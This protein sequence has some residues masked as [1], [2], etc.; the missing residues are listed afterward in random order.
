VYTAPSSSGTATVKASSG[1]VSG[2]ASV[3]TTLSQTLTSIVLSPAT[4]SLAAGAT[5]QFT[6]T[7]K[8]Q[9]GNPMS[10]QPA[11]TW[12]LSGVGTLS[13]SGLYTAPSTSG[14]ATVTASVGGVSGMASVTV[15]LSQTLTSIVLSPATVSLAAGATQQFTATAKDQ[16]GNPMSPQ[17]AFAWTLVSGGGTL[18]GS[19]L[20]TAPAN[21]GTATVKAS[22]A[23][24]SSNTASIT[25]TASSTP[26]LTS[27]VLYPGTVTVAP[28]APQVFTPAALDQFGNLMST[29][30]AYTFSVLSGS[31]TINSSGVYTAPASGSATIQVSAGGLTATAS[32]TVDSA[33]TSGIFFDS[34][35]GILTIKTNAYTNNMVVQVVTL[36]SVQWLSV[37]FSSSDQLGHPVLSLSQQ[38]ALSQV[39]YIYFYGQAAFNINFTNTSPVACTA[40]GGT[41]T[42]SL[43]GGSGN[44]WLYAGASAPS[45]SNSLKG[46]GGDDTLVGGTGT[47]YLYGGTGNNTLIPGFGTNF[48][49]PNS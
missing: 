1:S 15:T 31:G 37:T 28:G 9:F 23:T 12:A 49:Y 7:A 20:Y 11:F 34:S 22:C 41:G 29:P 25:I 6:A 17:P 47:N 24:V 14:T 42:N 40:F 46:L 35:T 8:D 13:G 48:L 36:N 4:V 26:V 33:F 30:P 2:T 39:S 27:L 10:P 16:F 45:Y 3:T 43:Q 19:G 18:N 32:V 44:D 38:F 21:S 5:Q